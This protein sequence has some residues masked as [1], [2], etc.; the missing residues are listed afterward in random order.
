MEIIELII[1][2][3]LVYGGFY[4]AGKLI[5]Y[6]FG[7][8][9]AAA[10]ATKETVMGRGSFKENMDLELR[11]MGAMELRGVER[12]IGE[13][14]SK[15]KVIELEVKGLFPISRNRNAAFV[16]SVLDKTD[17]ENRWKSVVSVVSQFQ[18]HDTTSY[19]NLTNVGEIKESFGFPRW[20][21]IGVVIRDVLQPARSGS[22]RLVALT[23]LI[24][25][26]DP[27]DINYGFHDANEKLIWM[28]THEFDLEFTQPG[29]LDEIEGKRSVAAATVKLAVVTSMA[30]GELHDRE[31][32]LIRG[33]IQKKL[34]NID[35]TMLSTWK[36]ELN[37][38]FKEAFHQSQ[39]SNLSYSE[40]IDVLNQDGSTANKIECVDLLFSI[41]A[42]DGSASASEVS[43]AKKIAAA[44]DIDT[45]EIQRI[46]DRSL[47]GVHAEV[48]SQSDLEELLGID[49]TWSTEITKK[50]LRDEFQ[51]WNNRL[52]ALSDPAERETAQ[53]MLNLIAEARKKYQ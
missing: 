42:A 20:V 22:R 9:A 5:G 25:T 15:F 38:A 37:S 18:E 47:V 23:R 7:Y 8:G 21:R 36:D 35:E 44:L 50:H 28:G 27:P 4:L 33:W 51:R 29:Y 26:D 24:D 1:T 40:L 43:L 41:V 39:I 2:L 13:A 10:K 46:A 45:A 31:G 14:G 48:S 32:E 30:D 52:T 49:P 19:R 6:V 12:E 11:G 3:V 16:T 17:G 34:S 53:R